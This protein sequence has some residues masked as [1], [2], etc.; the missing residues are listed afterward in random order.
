M[1][2]R[3]KEIILKICHFFFSFYFF[4]FLGLHLQHMEVPRL[5]VE[6]ELQLPT[7]TT[8]TVTLDL[9]H[10]CHLHYSSQQ[11][12]ILN[13]LS[14]V[15]NQTGVLMDTNWFRYHWGTTG[16]P[17]HHSFFILLHFIIL[18]DLEVVCI[19]CICVGK[20]LY[21]LVIP[22]SAAWHNTFIP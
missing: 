10:I 5:G 21:I 12:W 8:A 15:R 22:T 19:Y 1:T 3:T 18:C 16:T 20:M 2:W 7:Y 13:L 6:L 9:S 17:I 14:K 11:C 4:V